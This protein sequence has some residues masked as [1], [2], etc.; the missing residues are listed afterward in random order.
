M[1]EK[2]F[3]EAVALAALEPSGIR[4][5][6]ALLFDRDPALAWS[7]V[8]VMG[9]LAAAH[10]VKVKRTLSR[11]AYSLNDE[12]STCAW[13]AAPAVAEMTVANPDLTRDVV[14]I[15]LHY[16]EDEETSHG[17]NR[18]VDVLVSAL[19]AIGRVADVVPALVAEVMPTIR[20]FCVDLDVVVRAHAFWALARMAP[21]VA[22]HEVR[23]DDQAMA[24][25]FDPDRADWIRQPVFQFAV[26][27][28]GLASI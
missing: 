8:L 10:P 4:K 18:N 25:V 1:R 3:D 16:F 26:A 28:T 15:I 11:L 7:A 20:R 9:G 22:R 6:Y 13:M 14:R 27:P 23:E 24:A 17:P 21:E 12:A 5:V 19:W 2:R